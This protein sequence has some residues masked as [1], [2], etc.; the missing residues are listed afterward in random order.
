MRM[1]DEVVRSEA[2]SQS[3]TLTVAVAMCMWLGAAWIQDYTGQ[4]Y[5]LS[6]SLLVQP[7]G[8]VDE[9]SPSVQ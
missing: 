6:V 1:D 7:D 4:S 2:S 8:I 5:R 3:E 9:Y